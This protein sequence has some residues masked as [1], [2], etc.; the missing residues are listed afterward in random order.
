MPLG[1]F[2][3]LALKTGHG[4]PGLDSSY[5]VGLALSGGG[6][7][8]ALFGLGVLMALRDAGKLPRQIASVSG[9]SITNAFLA[10]RFFSDKARDGRVDDDDAWADATRRLFEM[11]VEQGVLTRPWI[12]A[13]A[14][15][16]GLPPLLLGAAA[17]LGWLTWP[18]IALLTTVWLTAALLR[19]LLVEK[20]IA[21]RLFGRSRR[22]LADLESSSLEHAICCTDLVTGRPVYASTRDGGVLF[23]RLEDRSSETPLTVQSGDA[24]KRELERTGTLHRIPGLSAA[25]LVRASSGFP[26]I[27]PRR[28]RLDASPPA[29]LSDGGI[30]NNL[31]TQP[32]EDAFLWTHDGPWVV[33]TADA[34]SPLD[35]APAWQFQIPGWAEIAA[36]LRQ[37]TILNVNTVLPRRRVFREEVRRELV[38]ARSARFT[39]ERLYPLVSIED[40]PDTILERTDA[41]GDSYDDAFLVESEVERRQERRDEL[42]DRV[43]SL[44]GSEKLAE[45]L[46]MSGPRDSRPD[47]VATAPTTLGRIDRDTALAIVG[48]GYANTAVTLY[49]TLLTDTISAPS[50]WIA[51]DRI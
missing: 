31:A 36:L 21:R 43:G 27:P 50:G 14:V 23:R 28:I 34:S 29:L 8:A 11:I 13:L 4:G 20:L 25:G 10:D 38:S 41:Y 7:R 24:Q 12:S 44:R 30:W 47:P 42:E 15:L 6:H 35:N 26:G 33:L 49:L 48:R 3:P 18:T 1:P 9:G 32:F 37:A 45:L 39:S 2:P 22:T 17:L 40:T 51:E 16:L 5:P 19:G 46:R